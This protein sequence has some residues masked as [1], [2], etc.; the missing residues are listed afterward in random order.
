MLERL[1][2]S[3][4]SFTLIA[5]LLLLMSYTQGRDEDDRLKHECATKGSNR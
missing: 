3:A 1:K 4:A 2:T 5:L